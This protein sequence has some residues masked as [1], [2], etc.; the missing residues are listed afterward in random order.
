MSL[1]NRYVNIRGKKKQHNKQMCS[2]RYIR[3]V[4]KTS[5]HIMPQSRA[6]IFS[7]G[8]TKSVQP[9]PQG[10]WTET[11]PPSPTLDPKVCIM[12][13][14][15][16]MLYVFLECEKAYIWVWT[17]RKSLHLRPHNWAKTAKEATWIHRQLFRLLWS[18]VLD[19]PNHIY[20]CWAHLKELLCWCRA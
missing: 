12:T 17:S 11:S 9:W 15:C 4:Y 7:S 1:R 2:I 6:S 3:Y 14:V 8:A 19:V 5:C 16:F 20:T 10:A 18:D 13:F